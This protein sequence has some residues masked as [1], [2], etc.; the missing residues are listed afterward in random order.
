MKNIIA[1][2]LIK[3]AERDEEYK[4]QQERQATMELVLSA[5]VETLSPEARLLFQKK[6][7]HLV[8]NA[9]ET[10]SEKSRALSNIRYLEKIT[11]ISRS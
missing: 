6:I 1:E 8:D 4:L 7:E 11:G 2:L 9:N 3:L 5:L 10:S